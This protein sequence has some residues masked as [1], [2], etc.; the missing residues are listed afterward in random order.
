MSTIAK[1]AICGLLVLALSVPAFA[2]GVPQKKSSSAIGKVRDA[3]I[4]AAVQTEGIVSGCLK[5]CF[6]LFNPCL[7]I[8]KSCTKVVLTP[9]EKPF[10]YVES[11][12][13]AP[14]QAKRTTKVPEPKK[15]EV[16]K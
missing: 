10:E 14:K 6:S 11:K 16:P 2:D 12:L 5:N 9:I 8:V 1:L 3:G 4:S 13:Y 7:D 15:P